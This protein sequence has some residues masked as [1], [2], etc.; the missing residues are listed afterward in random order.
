MGLADF[1][2]R[3]PSQFSGGQQQRVAM[4]RALARGTGIGTYGQA[5]QQRRSHAARTLPRRRSERLAAHGRRQSHGPAAHHLRGRPTPGQGRCRRAT[6]G[7]RHHQHQLAERPQRLRHD[8]RVHRHQVRCHRLQRGAA[9]GAGQAALARVRRRTGAAST[10]ICAATTRRSS[11]KFSTPASATS[12]GCR[13]RTS[14]TPSPT[15]SPAPGTWRSPNCSYAPPSRPEHPTPGATPR[16]ARSHVAADT[17]VTAAH[18][19]VR[20]CLLPAAAIA[21]RDGVQ[22]LAQAGPADTAEADNAHGFLPG[23]Y[24]GWAP[25]VRLGGGNDPTAGSARLL[26]GR[27][28]L[29]RWYRAAELPHPERL[30]QPGGR[31]PRLRPPGVRPPGRHRVGALR[32]TQVQIQTSGG[33]RLRTIPGGPMQYR[34]HL[35]RVRRPGGRTQGAEFS[36]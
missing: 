31:I 26:P 13:A 16:Q 18:T 5:G 7:R 23:V 1:E 17:R 28:D 10:P 35:R 21:L 24:V 33:S 4:A 15:S 25:P 12:G 22:Q 29:P 32:R 11:S 3:K 34:R 20:V 8:G 2:K 9:P 36:L 30:A 27:P 19:I 14:P 6:P